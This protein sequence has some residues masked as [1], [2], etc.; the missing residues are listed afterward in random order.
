MKR[1]ASDTDAGAPT[2]GFFTEAEARSAHL[3]KAWRGRPAL[4]EC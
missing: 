4:I 3:K 2:D 1:L